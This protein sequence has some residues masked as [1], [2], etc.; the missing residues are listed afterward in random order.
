MSDRRGASGDDRPTASVSDT[1][2]FGVPVSGTPAPCRGACPVGTDAA[3]YVALLAEGRVADAYDVARQH[4][5]FASVCGRVCSAPCERACRRG[6]IDSAVSIRAMKRVLCEVHGAEQGR[7]SR[8]HLAGGDVPKATKPSVGIIGA[9]PAGLASAHDLRLAGHAVTVYDAMP[10]AG[11]MMRYGIPAFRLPR[12]VLDAELAA[13]AG[14]GVT[15]R[16]GCAIGRDVPF[17]DLLEAH[18][19]VLVTV[20]CQQGRTLAVEGV[21][22]PG[23]MRA[24]DFLRAE[25]ARIEHDPSLTGALAGG[26]VVV[27]GGGSVAFDAARSAWRTPF[28]NAVG[29]AWRSLGS[30]TQDGQ[31]ALD[32][33][34]SAAR[35]GGTG[36]GTAA[37]EGT[38]RVTL[39]AP[40][41][42]GAFPVPAEELH[43]ATLEG[44]TICD[45]MGVVRLVGDTHVTGVEVAP[46]ER[47]FDA[48]GRFAPQLDLARR[49]TLPAATVVLAIGQQSDTDFLADLPDI[50]RTA[51]GG[52]AV[53]GTLRSTHPRVWAAGDVATGPR[54]LIDAVAAGQRAARAI[55]A[56]LGETV[57]DRR[58]LAP[59]VVHRAPPLQAST[60]FWSR[61]DD[62]RRASLP[63]LPSAQRDAVAEVEQ[64]LDLVAA[65][66]E[67]ARC[68]RCDEQ[69][70][71]APP[72]CIACALCVDVCPQASLALVPAEPA[73]A[74]PGGRPL[75][76]L[77]D[78]ATCI[79]CGLC[80][81][82]CP[83]DALRF[84]LAPALVP[85]VLPA[86]EAVL[87]HAPSAP[88]SLRPPAHA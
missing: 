2:P 28:G 27:I 8:W 57:H 10:L 68:L 59:P 75:A 82:R 19:A 61:Y 24:V 83:T 80:V 1:D 12:A 79:R 30:D 43:E 18:A 77:F 53:D 7:A 88:V 29:S 73:G 54:D 71:F 58:A 52:I 26:D 16:L 74:E 4:N 33:A 35:V 31:T 56:A 17:R 65:R 5:P 64:A 13:I 15:M 25:N 42:R 62:L 3:A 48:T 6:V 46:V 76:L 14:L 39:V 34:R 38:R 20:G 49:T 45:G 86:P 11:G 66:A 21:G 37:G 32:A 47:L 44:V 51:W 23:V 63:V 50:I 9:G 81:H 36:R 72:R 87:P 67:G 85:P 60:R 40:E 84:T 69:L 41:S 22:L 70:Q 55:A 78:D